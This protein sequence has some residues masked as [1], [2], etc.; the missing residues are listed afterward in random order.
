[1]FILLA[2]KVRGTALKKT[3]KENVIISR[4]FHVS[5]FTLPINIIFLI[6]NERICTLTELRHLVYL[7]VR[8]GM[9]DI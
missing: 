1:M 9:A 5:K 3:R 8:N 4:I 7:D 6:L 2:I